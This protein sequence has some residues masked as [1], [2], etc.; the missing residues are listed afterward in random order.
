LLGHDEND[1]LWSFPE[2]AV[3]MHFSEMVIVGIEPPFKL[4]ATIANELRRGNA[5]LEQI[6]PESRTTSEAAG[7]RPQSISISPDQGFSP[8]TDSNPIRVP[9][10]THG[11]GDYFTHGNQ[12][13]LYKDHDFKVISE[14]L[15]SSGRDT[16]SPVPRIY[17]VLRTIGQLQLIDSFL[18]QGIT[19][20]WFPFSTSSLPKVLSGTI[21]TQFLDAQ[22][23]VLTKGLSLEK[24]D[25]RKHAQFGRGETLPF[26]VENE[27][28]VG[29]LSQVHKITSITSHRQFVRKRFQRWDVSRNAAEI[30]GFIVELQIL[31]KI[32]HHH[33]VELVSHD[34]L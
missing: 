32:Q 19:D 29:R 26:T 11:L 30:E 4:P 10:Q 3:A 13:R 17:T 21:H 7:D 23:A 33:C 28:G 8:A 34:N 6:G 12:Q 20:I 25:S 2:Y 31:K 27:L 1:R 16:W 18:D 22:K 14:L 9:G 15:K 5:R 24:D